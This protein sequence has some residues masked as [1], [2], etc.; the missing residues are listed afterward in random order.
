M[1]RRSMYAGPKGDEGGV[2]RID[3]DAADPAAQ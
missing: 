1:A 2:S 3:G